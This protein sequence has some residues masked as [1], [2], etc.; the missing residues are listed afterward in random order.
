MESTTDAGLDAGA[1]TQ[2]SVKTQFSII[3]SHKQ[4]LLNRIEDNHAVR[5]PDA[6]EGPV[7]ITTSGLAHSS[8][9]DGQRHLIDRRI[10][11]LP[12]KALS[13]FIILLLKSFLR[14]NPDKKMPEAIKFDVV[15]ESKQILTHQLSTRYDLAHYP[16][17]KWA[18]TTLLEEHPIAWEMMECLEDHCSFDFKRYGSAEIDAL[19]EARAEDM[20]SDDESD[21]F[22]DV[23]SDASSDDDE[24][25]IHRENTQVQ[26]S[27]GR[28][29]K[30][31]GHIAVT[32]AVWREIT[33]AVCACNRAFPYDRLEQSQERFAELHSREDW[34]AQC[35]DAESKER[36]A[37]ACRKYEPEED[38]NFAEY[39]PPVAETMYFG[40]TTRARNVPGSPSVCAD[41]P[42]IPTLGKRKAEL[43]DRI[44]SSI[45]KAANP[46][47]K[48][49]FLELAR[50]ADTADVGFWTREMMANN[51]FQ[52]KRS[53][54][55]KVVPTYGWLLNRAIEMFGKE[56][57]V[58]SGEEVGQE[59]TMAMM[60]A[61]HDQGK[62]SRSV[63]RRRA[64][65]EMSEFRPRS[66]LRFEKA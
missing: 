58:A 9:F 42:E 44:A 20:E 47:H 25:N 14:H 61:L 54:R 65:S 24:C 64:L 27:A 22:S 5:N 33:A 40:D 37:I 23:G 18:L 26:G 60:L 6:P 49:D 55:A 39:V 17:T 4:H 12:T 34:Q 15:Y 11:A 21:L 66:S 52:S 62:R 43:Q 10:F 50:T 7:C 2:K 48:G 13:R 38:K 56:Y 31:K 53:S 8:I 32:E 45:L 19:F 59:R 36:H 30:Q 63:M 41:A 3:P 29:A 46:R 1:T 16:S 57:K 28:R 51:Q 35:K